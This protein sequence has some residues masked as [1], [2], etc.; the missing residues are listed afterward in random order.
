MEYKTVKCPNCSSNVL[1]NGKNAHCDYC[2]TDFV[3]NY[4][5]NDIKMKQMEMQKENMEKAEA[6]IKPFFKSFSI[7]HAIVTI[8]IL[9]V[10]LLIFFMVVRHFF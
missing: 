4:D 1:I 9:C 8:F 7:M 6:I 3:M 5:E 10:F 2:G